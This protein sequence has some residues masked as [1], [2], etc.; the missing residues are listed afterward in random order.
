MT[1]KKGDIVFVSQAHHSTPVAGIVLSVVPATSSGLPQ[2]NVHIV[3]SAD[4]YSSVLVPHRE[5]A[6]DHGY[7]EAD[8]GE[9]LEV[10]PQETNN[11][12]APQEHSS[13][14]SEGA[15]S[16]G[17][18]SGVVREEPEA[19]EDSEPDSETEPEEDSTE[20]EVDEREEDETAPPLSAGAEDGKPV[21]TTGRKRSGRSRR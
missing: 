16:E 11:A 2:A 3:S 21:P 20:G 17:D 12:D 18:G 10:R 4:P 19:S 15:D 6:D 8:E 5:Y 1:V 7:L 9:P 14:E 13:G